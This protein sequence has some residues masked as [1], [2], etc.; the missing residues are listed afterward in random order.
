MCWEKQNR[1][2]KN[3]LTRPRSCLSL[4]DA[5]SVMLRA[6]LEIKQGV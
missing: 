5:V 6:R 3:L 2:Y 4:S 1:Q